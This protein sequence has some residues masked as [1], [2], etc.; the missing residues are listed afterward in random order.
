MKVK[1]FIITTGLFVVTTAFLYLIG[2]MFTIPVLMFHYEYTDSANGFFTTTG[3]V[4][5]LIIGLVISFIAEKLY[6]YKYRQKHE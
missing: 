6:I 2:N 5:P 3:S 1:S 4:V